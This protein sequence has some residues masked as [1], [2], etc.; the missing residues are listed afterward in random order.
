M[1]VGVFKVPN[2]KNLFR[3]PKNYRSLMIA[4][5][6]SIDNFHPLKNVYIPSSP[7]NVR[8]VQLFAIFYEGGAQRVKLSLIRSK[9]AW[10]QSIIAT[11]K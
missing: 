6:K 8:L 5:R 2:S 4:H 10:G 1:I 11:N 9:L 7:S 3:N